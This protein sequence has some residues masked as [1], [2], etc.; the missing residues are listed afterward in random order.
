MKER[1][2]TT[3]VN[4]V[5]VGVVIVLTLISGG[6]TVAKIRKHVNIVL[7]NRLNLSLPT[8]PT[9]TPKRE[10]TLKRLSKL[11]KRLFS[12]KRKD[13]AFEVS[14]FNQTEDTMVAAG[15]DVTQ[16]ESRYEIVEGEEQVEGTQDVGG[17][18]SQSVTSETTS[19]QIEPAPVQ[20][21]PDS[22]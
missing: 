3:A 22:E 14:G 8:P 17:R 5:L 13:H 4:S 12:G 21:T 15:G 11:K 16:G 6:F 18:V 20:S 1:F 9:S 19:V 10:T 2:G 7:R